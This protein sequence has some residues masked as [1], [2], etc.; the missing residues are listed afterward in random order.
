ML[1]L[2]LCR[3]LD[4]TPTARITA[5]CTQ[6]ISTVDGPIA[7]SLMWV[8]DQAIGALMKL[9]VIALLTPIFLLPGVAIGAIGMLIGN[10]YLKAQLSVKREMRYAQ[11]CC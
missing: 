6:D 3:W 1:A 8:I 4:E 5:R 9:F 11:H 7:Q 10:V 2:I